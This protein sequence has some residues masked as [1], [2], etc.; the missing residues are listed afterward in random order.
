MGLHIR[1]I[2]LCVGIAL[3]QSF[4][5]F[6]AHT[7]VFEGTP[8][9]DMDEAQLLIALSFVSGIVGYALLEA[10]VAKPISAILR[11]VRSAR[12]S[13]FKDI[14]PMPSLSGGNIK[15]LATEV[16]ASVSVFWEMQKRLQGLSKQKEEFVTIASHQLRTPFTELSWGVESLINQKP[17]QDTQ[18]LAA[19][20]LVGLKRM[21]VVVANLVNTAAMEEGTFGYAFENVD[22]IAAFDELLNEYQPLARHRNIELTFQHEAALPAIR[23]DKVRIMLAF[24]NLLSN[25]IDYTPQGGHVSI[26]IVP[27]ETTW[28]CVIEDS[29][30]GIPEDQILLIFN[31]FYR[32][33]NARHMRQD[34]S[35]I[36]LYVSRN[37][38][39]AHH[40]SITVASREQFGSRFTVSLPY[41]F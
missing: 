11:W 17:G 24:S 13:N 1:L 28:D 33:T 12:K 15:N 27:H 19:G 30:I 3:L 22:I 16:A 40:G 6:V 38:I 31:K 39:E 34:G 20:I 36:G 14:G 32:G 26:A 18:A 9:K 23:A 29:G 2:L 10:M 25:A 8:L 37:I 5:F 35:G 7:S 41:K 21:E 4:L